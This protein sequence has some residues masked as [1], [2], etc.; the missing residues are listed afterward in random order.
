MT[1]AQNIRN[2]INTWIKADA[3]AAFQNNRL[4][5][6]LNMLNSSV[7][8]LSAGVSDAR[9]V[10]VTQANFINATDCPITS[11]AGKTISVYMNTDD[12]KRFLRTWGT[13]EWTDL[14]GGGFKILIDGFD[15]TSE[16]LDF[17][18]YPTI[19]P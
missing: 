16:N 3:V 10:H 1:V 14:V 17:Y 18:V 6:A 12:M 19:T 15:G 13:A 7:E 9:V 2:F 11:L 5:T 4:N 8:T